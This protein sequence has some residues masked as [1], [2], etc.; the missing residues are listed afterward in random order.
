MRHALLALLL[1]APLAAQERPALAPSARAFVAVDAPVV[2]LTGVRLV[3]GTGAPAREGHTVVVRGTRIVAVGPARTT[4]VPR[5]ARVMD[6]AGHTLMPGL[7]SLHEHTYFG[8]LRQTVPMNAGAA[9]YLGSG[10]TTAMTAGSQLPHQEL[11]LK[12][13]IDSGTLP[14]PRLLVTGPYFTGGPGR[15]SGGFVAVRDA[16]DAKRLVGLWAAKGATWFKVHNGPTS[17]LRDVIQAAHARGLRVSAHLCSVTFSEAAALG[18]DA[19]QHGFITNS[20]YVPGK[21]PDVCPPE[22]MRAQADVDVASPAVQESIRRIVAGRAA[23]VSTL[24]VYE[25]FV[26][27]R[28][29]DAR[30]LEMLAPA[31]RREVEANHA[32]LAQRGFTV[33]ERLLAKMMQW[34]RA[35]VAA[36]GLLGAGSDP[37]GTGFLPGFGNLRNYELLVQA[38]FRPEEAIQILTLNGARI[39]GEEARIGSIA[40]GKQADLVVVRGDPLAAPARIYDVTLVFRD[41]IGYDAVRLRDS[42]KGRVGVF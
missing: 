4:P 12:R 26:P 17:V 3:D 22:N 14:G 27:G 36:G 2:A 20:E 33:P 24:G 9:L 31:T 8:G 1:A 35:F 23:V 38:G 15:G 16:A 37:W 7:V 34:E 29:L 30:A 18:I 6:L 13:M 42:A 5:G 19:L 39:L 41:G 10:V 32:G 40:P 11:S 25:S 21:Q 28:P